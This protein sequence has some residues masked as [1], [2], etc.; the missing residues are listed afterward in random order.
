MQ[1]RQNQL[2]M[3]DAAVQLAGTGRARSV[4]VQT[5]VVRVSVAS[6]NPSKNDAV[7]VVPVPT[8]LGKVCL[9]QVNR[10]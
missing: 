9:D 8:R 7:S 6:A 10:Q 3:A 2:E 4:A 1:I 5:D